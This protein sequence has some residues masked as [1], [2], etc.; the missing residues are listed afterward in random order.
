MICGWWLLLLLLILGY[1]LFFCG[2]EGVGGGDNIGFIDFVVG[3][4]VCKHFLVV[5]EDLL[6]VEVVVKFIMF[7][8]LT[9]E[10]L[11]FD[12]MSCC[13]KKLFFSFNFC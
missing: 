11:E 9:E 2:I 8:V 10:Q 4:G 13:F 1:I 5:G 3:D 7:A 12:L 6:F